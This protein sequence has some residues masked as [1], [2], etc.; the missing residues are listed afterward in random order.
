MPIDYMANLELASPLLPV[1]Y[2]FGVVIGGDKEKRTLQAELNAGGIKHLLEGFVT[3]SNQGG[4]FSLNLETPVSGINRATVEAS[5]EFV[6]KTQIHITCSF[7]NKVNTFDFNFDKENM[8]FM[9]ALES[10]F[11]PTGMLKAEAKITGE[12]NK[13]MQL[14]INL[15]NNENS[16]SGVLN[17]KI[18][19][20]QNI[21]VNLKITTPFKGYKKMGFAVQYLKNSE[22]VNVLLVAEKPVKFNVELRLGNFRENIKADVKFD[23]EIK[24]FEAIEG[25]LLITLN[26]FEPRISA[27][28]MINGE[29]YKGHIGV[30]TKAPYEL[31][32]GLHLGS[33][34]DQK[35]HLRTDSSFLFFL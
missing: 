17:T 11:I 6:P 2:V 4:S 25:H 28:M 19:S 7:A 35:F 3:M 20:P 29:Y 13:N 32:Y 16:M 27:G 26:S 12:I 31:T 30:K 1:D 14:K 23:T 5:V 21:K 10:P 18:A 15:M 34:V 24:S 9:S 8:A 33:L 22:E